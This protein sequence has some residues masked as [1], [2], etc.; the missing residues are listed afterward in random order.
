MS[1]SLPRVLL[2]LS[3]L[4]ATLAYLSPAR[5]AGP[6]CTVAASDSTYPSVATVLADPGCTTHRIEDYRMTDLPNVDLRHGVVPISKAAAMLAAL[7]TRSR[8]ERRPIIIAQKGYP[9]G[10]LLNITL[11]TALR[12]LARGQQRGPA[13]AG[14]G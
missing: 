4:L 14:K 9:S 1:R 11:Y 2:A 13:E 3:L 12:D 5:A 7:L 6:I 10:V 8:E